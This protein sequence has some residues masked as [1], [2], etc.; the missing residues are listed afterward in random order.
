M[1]SDSINQAISHVSLLSSIC[2]SV[3]L[4]CLVM[5][6]DSIN[7]AISHVSLLSSICNSVI[8]DRVLY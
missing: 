7:Q 5:W 6:S 1:Q 2:N 4:D 3:I 8:L